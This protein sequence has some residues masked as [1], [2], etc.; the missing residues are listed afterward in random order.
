MASKKQ[1]GGKAETRKAKLEAQLIEKAG[2]D[3][4][5][6]LLSATHEE[7]REKTGSLAKYEDETEEAQ[8]KDEEIQRL[9]EELKAAKGPYKDTLAGIKLQRKFIG[10]L[11][12]EKGKQTTAKPALT[13]VQV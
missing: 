6:T 7:L 10:M 3:V 4:V 12:R 1:G 8:E 11:L 13:A 9:T 5:D 2:Q